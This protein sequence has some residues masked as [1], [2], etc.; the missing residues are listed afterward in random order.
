MRAGN[1]RVPRHAC[2]LHAAGKKD[3]WNGV[4]GGLASGGVIGLRV[5]RVPVG[6]GAA[7]ALA[8]TSAAVD[9]SGGQLVGSGVFH[10]GATPRHATYPYK[11]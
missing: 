5:G 10:D 4:L 8:A 1:E 6:V 7:F 3:M 9:V 11:S 2:T